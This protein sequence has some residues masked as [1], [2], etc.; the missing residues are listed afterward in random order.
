[1]EHLDKLWNIWKNSG[2]M[3]RKTGYTAE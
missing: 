2:E 3:G 1:M